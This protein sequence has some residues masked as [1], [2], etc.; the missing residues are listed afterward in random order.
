M[1]VTG[2]GERGLGSTAE[3]RG[4]AVGRPEL[5]GAGGRVA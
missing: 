4:G 5:P 3:C 1:G 2:R